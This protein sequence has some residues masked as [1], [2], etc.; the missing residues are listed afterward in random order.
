MQGNKKSITDRFQIGRFS[1]QVL[2]LFGSQKHQHKHF[3]D[4]DYAHNDKFALLHGN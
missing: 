3:E 4:H 1:N 2:L